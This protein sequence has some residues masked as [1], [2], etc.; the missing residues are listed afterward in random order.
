[1]G[2]GREAR[3]IEHVEV[4]TPAGDARAVLDAVDAFGWGQ[5]FL[6]NVGDEKGPILDAAIARIDARRIL[7]LG[8]YCG[9]SSLRMAIAAPLARI[10][11]IEASAEHAAIARRLHRH[12]G[13]AEQID[14]VVGILGDGGRT[15]NVLEA[16]HGFGEGTVDLVFIDHAKEAYLADLQLILQRGWLRRGGLAV[17]DN[18]KYPGAPEYHAMMTAEEGR[19]WRTEEHATFVEYQ[20]EIEDLVLVSEWLGERID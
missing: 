20:R 1:M 3:L 16:E 11:S 4:T 10:T 15:A 9:Y 18:V 17:A 5:T 7:E 12:A 2:D 6:M 19:A 14:I 8:T 13:V